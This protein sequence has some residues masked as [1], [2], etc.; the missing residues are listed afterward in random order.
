MRCLAFIGGLR[1]QRDVEDAGA[2]HRGASAG[3]AVSCGR[4][5]VACLV[6]EAGPHL[7]R[8]PSLRGRTSVPGR[9]LQVA[10]LLT[11][12]LGTA[13][14]PGGSRC[15]RAPPWEA[16]EG[17]AMARA[18]SRAPEGGHDQ[19]CFRHGRTRGAAPRTSRRGLGNTTRRGWPWLLAAV[20]QQLRARGLAGR[21]SGAEGRREKKPSAPR[22][23]LPSL[24]FRS[25]PTRSPSSSAWRGIGRAVPGAGGRGHGRSGTGRGLAQGGRSQGRPRPGAAS[26]G[27]G[28]RGHRLAQGPDDGRSSG[29]RRRPRGPRAGDEVANEEDEAYSA[30]S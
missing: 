29:A 17:C 7:V 4:E 1:R 25:G 5:G 20:S 30:L 27:A 10:G 26:H 21:N 16:G 28:R 22:N 13:S 18:A 23:R 11:A 6:V 24:S 3:S 14:A 8:A 19:G 2:A 9:P 12:S 15:C